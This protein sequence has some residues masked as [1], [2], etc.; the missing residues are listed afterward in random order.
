MEKPVP[1]IEIDVPM[2]PQTNKG[3]LPKVSPMAAIGILT[4]NRVNPITDTTN[5]VC[6]T[7]KKKKLDFKGLLTSKK[8]T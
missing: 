8:K 4:N 2:G 7:T 5:P 1:I 3:F 6:K